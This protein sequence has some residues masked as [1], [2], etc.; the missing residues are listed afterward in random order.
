MY[1]MERLKKLS[2]SWNVLWTKSAKKDYERY[3]HKEKFSGIL[4]ALKRNPHYGANI[5]RLHG[6]WEGMYRY[7]K[8]NYRIIY[9]IRD[10]ELIVLLLAIDVR[11]SVY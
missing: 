10:Q 7:R 2:S 8:G 3:P 4:E 1:T 5:K 11:G 6:E 9:Q